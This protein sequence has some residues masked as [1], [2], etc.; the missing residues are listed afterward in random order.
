MT[1]IA[2]PALLFAPKADPALKPNHPIHSIAAPI[3]VSIGLCGGVKDLGN[4]L[5]LP[6]VKAVTNAAVPAV[7]H[8]VVAVNLAVVQQN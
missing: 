5:L 3:I 1:N 6:R 7:G 4:P 8:S 2:I